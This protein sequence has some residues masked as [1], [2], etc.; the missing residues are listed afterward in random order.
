M[1]REKGLVA[2]LKCVI[3]DLG[4]FQHSD[5]HKIQGEKCSH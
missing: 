4:L 3:D 1:R 2:S 5:G